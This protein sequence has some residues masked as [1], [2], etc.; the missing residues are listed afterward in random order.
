MIFLF[1]GKRQIRMPTKSNKK[2]K[3]LCLYARQ[4][5]KNVLLL[6]SVFVCEN[7]INFRQYFANFD[8]KTKGR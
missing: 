8:T 6:K 1:C 5:N 3:K 7:N 4:T 2:L